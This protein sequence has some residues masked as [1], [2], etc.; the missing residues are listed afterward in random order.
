[1]CISESSIYS[2][3]SVCLICCCFFFHSHQNI[4]TFL[5]V[6]SWL[7]WISSNIFCFQ[8]I[9]KTGNVFSVLSRIFKVIR[10]ISHLWR[11]IKALVGL[12]P[13]CCD[14]TLWQVKQY[15]EEFASPGYSPSL[16]GSQGS[17]HLEQ[18][19]IV[20]GKLHGINA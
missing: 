11:Q 20:K 2:S 5:N 14:K 3:K 4:P 7:F 16:G 10:R 1:M 19:V 9:W 17:R 18:L 15:K 13:Y 12:V 6:M 8:L